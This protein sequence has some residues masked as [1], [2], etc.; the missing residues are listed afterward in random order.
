MKTLPKTILLT[1]LSLTSINADTLTSLLSNT[2]LSNSL[3]NNEF[4]SLTNGLSAVCYG[5]NTSS[6]LRNNSLNLCG[7]LNSLTNL[8]SGM[9]SSLPSVPGFN[10]KSNT[11]GNPMSGLN[12]FCNLSPTQKSK[13]AI[14]NVMVWDADHRVESTTYPNGQQKST[15]YTSTAAAEKIVSKDSPARNAFKNN[16]QTTLKHI[17]NT[18]K[19]TDTNDASNLKNSD[20]VA[21]STMNDYDTQRNSIAT[22]TTSDLETTKA[23][24]I[25]GTLQTK[26]SGKK[27]ATAQ[28]AADEYA[29]QMRE[30]I[31]AGTAKRIGLYLDV[32]RKD[33]DFAIPTEDS[34]QYIKQDLRPKYT[35]QIQNQMKRE[36]AMIAMI[37][38]IDDN[39]KALVT[40]AANKAVIMNE[41]FD[42]VAA[43]NEIDALLQ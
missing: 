11:L 23:T 38:Q 43:Q 13:S 16:D 36:A 3:L 5:N 7:Y 34:I 32:A 27:G 26:L 22:I 35:A 31:D 41:P 2:S 19:V 17:V 29:S 25:S 14:S 40:L 39:R 28:Q 6:L 12:S 37:T 1:F 20:F 18:A 8:S 10:K 30:L 33:Q 21:P 4:G 24:N 15:F 42:A 9:C